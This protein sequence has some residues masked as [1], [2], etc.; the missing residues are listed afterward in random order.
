MFFSDELIGARETKITETM[1][2]APKSAQLISIGTIDQTGS[3]SEQRVEISRSRGLVLLG[4]MAGALLY[5]GQY[6]AVR[7]TKW[8]ERSD[9]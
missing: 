6:V 5:I 2:L 3:A 9:R 8:R 4:L 1:F 7:L